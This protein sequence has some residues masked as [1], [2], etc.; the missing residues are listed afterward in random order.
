WSEEAFRIYGFDPARGP[1][2]FEEFERRIHPDDRAR[3]REDLRTAIR[4]KVDF[5]HGYRIVHPGGEIREIHV[6]G[7]PVLAPSGDVVEFVGTMI[8]VTER[9]HAEEDRRRREASYREAQRL[10]HT[11]SLAGIPTLGLHTYAS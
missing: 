8:D 4:E 6:I 2:R 5:D 10:R 1:P 7:H 9:K 3:T 11:G